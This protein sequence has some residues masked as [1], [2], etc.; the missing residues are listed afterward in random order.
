MH[1]SPLSELYAADKNNSYHRGQ[2]VGARGRSHKPHTRQRRGTPCPYP[3]ARLFRARH[4]GFARQH[5]AQALAEVVAPR[6]PRSR[7]GVRHRNTP[8]LQ[9]PPSSGRIRRHCKPFVPFS[10]RIARRGRLCFHKPGVRQYFQGRIHSSLLA[11]RAA[12]KGRFA[13]HSPR[14][15]RALPPEPSS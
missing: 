9:K 10:R 15:S 6:P 8:Q 2:A 1:D 12:G 11:R 14:R 4:Q 13:L 3:Q 7:P 5:T